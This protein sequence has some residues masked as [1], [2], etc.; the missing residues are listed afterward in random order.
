[1]DVSPV[2]NKFLEKAR[3]RRTLQVTRNNHRD[4]VM[5]AHPVV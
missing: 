1:M 5:G 3:Q 4:M 2:S